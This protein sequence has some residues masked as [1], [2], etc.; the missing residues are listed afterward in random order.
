MAWSHQGSPGRTRGQLQ[1]QVG[2][3]GEEGNHLG[4]AQGLPKGGGG[5]GHAWAGE[6][7]QRARQHTWPPEPASRFKAQLRP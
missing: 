6:W 2:E 4:G 1:S 7:E 3:P 5:V